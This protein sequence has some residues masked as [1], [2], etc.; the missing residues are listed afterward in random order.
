MLGYRASTNIYREN[1]PYRDY[2][3]GLS[4]RLRIATPTTLGLPQLFQN[5]TNI[6]F[7]GHAINPGNLFVTTIPKTWKMECIRFKVSSMYLGV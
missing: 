6:L 4:R 7:V 1:C 5:L 2:N 3:P